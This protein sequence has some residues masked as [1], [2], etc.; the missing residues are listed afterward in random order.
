M[1]GLRT[2]ASPISPAGNCVASSIVAMLPS[3][4]AMILTSTPERGVPTQSPSPRSLRGQ[5]SPSTVSPSIS[6]TGSASV[7]P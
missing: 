4:I 7:A 5:V 2:I 3:S 1:C 6:A